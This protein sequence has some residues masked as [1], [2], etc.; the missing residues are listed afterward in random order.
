MNNDL[1][2]S[3]TTATRSCDT[4]IKNATKLVKEKLTTERSDSSVNLQTD[5]KITE[6]FEKNK[7]L[8]I[9]SD[10]PT[11]N[12][13][14][15]KFLPSEDKNPKSMVTEHANQSH[16]SCEMKTGT[17]EYLVADENVDPQHLVDSMNASKQDY[18]SNEVPDKH[19]DLQTKTGMPV[20]EKQCDRSN[21]MPLI[22]QKSCGLLTT[23]KCQSPKPVNSTAIPCIAE[24]SCE[25]LDETTI[26]S[27]TLSV[28]PLPDNFVNKQQA[29]FSN[30]Q[31]LFGSGFISKVTEVA[32]E[33]PDS[34]SV[35]TEPSIRKP[36]DT[37]FGDFQSKELTSSKLLP[38]LTSTQANSHHFCPQYFRGLHQNPQKSLMTDDTNM[39]SYGY[40]AS[41][42]GVSSLS[43]LATYIQTTGK[44]DNR[45]VLQSTSFSSS[46][47]IPVQSWTTQTSSSN[48]SNSSKDS[49]SRRYYQP[50]NHRRSTFSLQFPMNISHSVSQPVSNSIGNHCHSHSHHFSVLHPIGI[51]PS[52]NMFEY[53][54]EQ[55][56]H[57]QNDSRNLIGQVY[58]SSRSPLQSLSQQN[59]F[60]KSLSSSS[61]TGIT[62]Q[63]NAY[64]VS[65]NQHSFSP[66]I[67]P[68]V[69]SAIHSINQ[70]T[71]FKSINN[72][73][74]N[75][76]NNNQFPLSRLRNSDKF[77]L[78][79]LPRR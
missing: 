66:Q 52:P 70:Y 37:K 77:W 27:T 12:S 51:M 53:Y 34:S 5:Q 55:P 21:E 78:G 18:E 72:N 76:S 43:P 6:A 60:K 20:W 15:T 56:N 79:S 49:K 41:G 4:D 1:V 42:V 59:I 29:V 13:N 26:S 50:P 75:S 69:T 38:Y 39:N 22:P 19:D 54:H 31:S 40:I 9:F 44:H 23:I 32:N 64:S 71:N 68:V 58:F 7:P 61:T 36:L 73:S 30:N 24:E 11:F 45:T 10:N 47:S 57:E 46:T 65:G 33:Q 17:F 8:K 28:S 67:L 63:E 16:E 14:N 25:T 62:K 2:Q 35:V 74:N 48:A 3:M